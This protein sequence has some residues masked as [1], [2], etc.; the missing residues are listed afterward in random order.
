M[1]RTI[2]APVYSSF[3]FDLLRRQR[4]E[5]NFT[6]F[7]TFAQRLRRCIG[8][9]HPAQILIGRFVFVNFFAGFIKCLQQFYSTKQIL[10]KLIA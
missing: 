9:P 8:L 4:S 2:F 6:S 10:C 7:Q 3:S 1:I 5:Q